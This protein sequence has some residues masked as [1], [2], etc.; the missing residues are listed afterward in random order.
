[1]CVCVCP[2]VGKTNCTH[3]DNLESQEQKNLGLPFA[4]PTSTM[5]R[6]SGR[7][8]DLHM[9]LP[10]LLMRTWGPLRRKAW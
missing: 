7:A 2:G 5:L 6:T 1:V 4:P 10:A 9:G 3:R 8:D